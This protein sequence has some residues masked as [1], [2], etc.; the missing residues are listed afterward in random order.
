MPDKRRKAGVDW[1]ALQTEYVTKNVTLAELAR[2]HDISYN[3]LT[4]HSSSEEWN[5]KR[6][7]YYEI[8]VSKTTN[9]ISND[10]A[11]HYK[12]IIKASDAL[13]ARIE[14]AV[15]SKEQAYLWDD[16]NGE[17]KQRDRVNTAF[18]SEIARLLGESLR[19]QNE[20]HGV[21]PESEW[22]S[23]ETERRKIEAL[24]AAKNE[25]E[26]DLNTGGVIV[27]PRINNAD[28]DA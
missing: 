4:H 26:G 15:S 25:P 21:L 22:Q 24:S 17:D 19:L 8:I 6:Q 5:K 13:I 18:L 10:V 9:R 7:E 14:E 16:K 1:L 12:R 11:K 23:I 3:T 27:L 28:G 2:A 20:I